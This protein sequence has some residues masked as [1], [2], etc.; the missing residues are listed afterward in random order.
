[1]AAI[2]LAL[3]ASLGWGISDYLGGLKSRSLPILSVLLVS[4]TTALAALLLFLLTSATALPGISFL[5]SAML[6][7]LGEM[8]GIVALYRGLSTGTMS[9]V[10][11]ISNAAPAIPLTV[12]LVLGEIPGTTQ[13]AG[14]VLVVAG[15]VLTSIERSA[16][17]AAVGARRN[18]SVVYGI[19][20]AIG[21]GTFFAAMD[22]AAEGAIIWALFAARLTSL[23]VIATAAMLM[24]SLGRSRLG[25]TKA[26]VPVLAMIGLLVVSAD[27][28]YAVAS[29]LGLLSVVGVLSALHPVVTVLLARLHLRE[30]MDGMRY[31]GIAVCLLGVMA[32]TGGA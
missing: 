3:G 15:I 21:F 11:P 13:L 30:H 22:S 24:M 14:L 12:A 26:E 31:A 20:S 19:I 29:T 25:L 5:L 18:A 28:M 16:G 2:L 6:A 23:V 27:A 17:R 1:M 9:V 7:G 4:Q 10:A 32:I 8:I